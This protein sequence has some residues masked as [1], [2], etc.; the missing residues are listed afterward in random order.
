MLVLVTSLAGCQNEPDELTKARA[1]LAALAATYGI[2]IVEGEPL[3]HSGAHE[4]IECKWPTDQAL[5]S[6]IPLFLEEFALYP[7]D[8]V[9]RCKL[10]RIVLCEDLISS[11]GDRAGGLADHEHG[12]LFLDISS[13]GEDFYLREAIH[14]EVFHFI[15]FQDDG[16]LHEDEEWCALN[17]DGF[18]YGDARR[19]PLERFLSSLDP[20][21]MYPGFLNRYSTT[22]VEEDKAVFFS[23]LVVDPSRVEA[24]AKND[25]VVREKAEWI[26]ALP[27]AFCPEMNHEFW[28]RAWKDRR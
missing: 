28:L 18:E 13:N 21:D 3:Y 7:V 23:T 4:S 1:R 22:G 8:V 20:T 6:Y 15:D 26:R 14:H 11:D 2:D 5:E 24:A 16:R 19:G 10:E 17:P 27:F 25:F 12:A 9:K